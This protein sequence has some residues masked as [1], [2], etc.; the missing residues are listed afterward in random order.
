MSPCKRFQ[1]TARSATAMSR[2]TVNTKTG[3]L[4]TP[5]VG[6]GL[7][8]I[9]LKGHNLIVVLGVILILQ[10]SIQDLPHFMTALGKHP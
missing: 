8:M 7:S 6:K 2:S 3:L 1:S 9:I 10:S 4:F 5:G